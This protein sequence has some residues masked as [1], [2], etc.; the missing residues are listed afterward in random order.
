MKKFLKKVLFILLILLFIVFIVVCGE[1]VF[2][3]EVV[4]KFVENFKNMKSVDVI[5][6]M[7]ME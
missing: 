7:K 6:I 2:K 5:M 1:K 4:E 3:K